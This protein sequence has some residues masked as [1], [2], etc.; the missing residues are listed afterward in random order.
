ME[1][2]L[3][4]PSRDFRWYDIDIKKPNL[5]LDLD[6]VE[7]DLGTRN[8]AVID[9]EYDNDL[10]DIFDY[11]GYGYDTLNKIIKQADLLRDFDDYELKQIAIY[12]RMLNGDLEDAIND[13]DN[14]YYM[15]IDSSDP[16]DLAVEYI[17]NFGIDEKLLAD[18]FDYGSFGGSLMINYPDDYEGNENEWDVGEEYIYDVYGDIESYI[19]AVGLDEAEMY[20]DTDAFGRDLAME[21]S[22]DAVSGTWISES[23]KCKSKKSM[24]ESKR[25]TR[26]LHIREVD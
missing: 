13:F 15:Y 26:K 17:R 22:Y 16:E 11:S 12:R 20:F 3:E 19:D 21:H 8:P 2:C 7:R 24:S 25:T 10:D 4:N 14:H 1:I 5:G 23:V 6:K 9:F 18:Y